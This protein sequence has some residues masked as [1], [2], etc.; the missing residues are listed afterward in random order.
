MQLSRSFTLAEMTLS[1]TA[2]RA[3][4]SNVPPPIAIGHLAMLCWYV[5]EPLRQKIGRPILISS[6][7]RSPQVNELV[8]GSASSLHRI[9]RAADLVVPGMA[10]RDV[11]K[12]V[13]DLRLPFTELILEFGEWTHV[14]VAEVGREPERRVL[15][16][17][18]DAQGE[19]VYTKGI[20]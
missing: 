10:P 4:L 15:T 17:R 18:R 1:E 5:L 7:Y 2:G 20:A 11:C 9:G 12:T 14:A 3:G 16:A 8:K 6:G 19:T 13:I